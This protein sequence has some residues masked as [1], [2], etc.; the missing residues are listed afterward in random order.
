MGAH[1]ADPAIVRHVRQCPECRSRFAAADMLLAV[2]APR[3]PADLTVRLRTAVYADARRRTYRRVLVSAIAMFWR[4]FRSS[5]R[6]RSA[7]R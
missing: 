3:V 2:Y 7:N 6:S 4:I 5:G 1:P